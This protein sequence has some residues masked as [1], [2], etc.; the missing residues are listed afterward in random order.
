MVTRSVQEI[1]ERESVDSHQE[2]HIECEMDTADHSRT[3]TRSQTLGAVQ[4]EGTQGPV[5][6]GAKE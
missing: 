3:V 2:M 1:Q 5:T 4:K 6:Q